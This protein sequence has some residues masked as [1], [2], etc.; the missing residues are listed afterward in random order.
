MIAYVPVTDYNYTKDAVSY[1]V[2][3][4]VNHTDH[5]CIPCLWKNDSNVYSAQD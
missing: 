2:G 3:H 5:V 4:L 1:D